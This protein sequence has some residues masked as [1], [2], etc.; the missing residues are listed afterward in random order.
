M[1]IV[2]NELCPYGP[3][4]KATGEK[5]QRN[6]TII[7]RICINERGQQATASCKFGWRKTGAD[8]QHR[9]TIG[10]WPGA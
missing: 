9:D 8:A 4:H 1:V 10:L 2:K 5:W 6:N 3:H 7:Q